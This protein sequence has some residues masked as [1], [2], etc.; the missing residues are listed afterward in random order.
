MHFNLR[1]IL[2]LFVYFFY[3]RSSISNCYRMIT[4]FVF[5]DF[6]GKP[7]CSDFQEAKPT[8]LYLEAVRGLPPERRP[9]L[10][11]LLRLPRYSDA[12]IAAIRAILTETGAADAVRGSI[13][14]L[15]GLAKTALQPLPDNPWRGM[16]D[17]LVDQ[18]LVRSV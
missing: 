3:L 4:F 7:L 8:M 14:A 6:F 9:E 13:V 5:G 1:L 15:S 10:D 11:A 2:N 16:L 18:M 12:D 17:T